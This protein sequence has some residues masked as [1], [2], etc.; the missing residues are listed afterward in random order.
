MEPDGI[1]VEVGDNI[2]I[3]NTIAIRDGGDGIDLCSRNPIFIHKS[4][5]VNTFKWIKWAHF[6]LQWRILHSALRCC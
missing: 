4:A 2:L 6:G 5:N 3:K 1:A